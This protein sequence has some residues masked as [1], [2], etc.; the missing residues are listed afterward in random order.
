MLDGALI[1]NDVVVADPEPGTLP[2]PLQPVQTY[3][4]PEPPETGEVTDAVML[5][6]AL[7]QP[8]DGLGES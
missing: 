3:R 7:N 8:L 1:V 5:E 4:V 6:P 2:V